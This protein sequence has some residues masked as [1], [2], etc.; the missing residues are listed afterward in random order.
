MT[1][2]Y[3][4]ALAASMLTHPGGD[5]ACKNFDD[6]VCWNATVVS[7]SALEARRLGRGVAARVCD[8][9]VIDNT[10]VHNDKA[11]KLSGQVVAFDVEHLR[12]IGAAFEI[13]DYRVCVP[14]VQYADW[15]EM[16]LCKNPIRFRSV[17]RAPSVVAAFVADAPAVA[18]TSFT[19]S[20]VA[21]SRGVAPI[22]LPNSAL[23]M[24]T[25]I[26]VLLLLRLSPSE[27]AV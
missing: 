13:D 4:L 12:A 9:D 19:S 22:P 17:A 1:A 3:T 10:S 6:A 2:A 25:G 21:T 18:T 15:L 7:A 20:F 16:A 26:A 24:L 5:S 11:H 27:R 8:G 14:A 23:A